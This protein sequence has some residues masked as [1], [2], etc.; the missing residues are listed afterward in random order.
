M[1]IQSY[2]IPN[3]AMTTNSQ[4][5]P[6]TPA[7]AG[8]LY[9]KAAGVLDGAWCGKNETKVCYRGSHLEELY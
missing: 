2:R 8:R 3:Q 4:L 7:A 1:G 9:L 5:T 6:T